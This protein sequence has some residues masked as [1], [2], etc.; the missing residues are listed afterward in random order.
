MPYRMSVIALVLGVALSILPGCST[1]TG[2]S[3]NASSSRTLMTE[4]ASVRKSL[5]QLVDAYENKQSTRFMALVAE[6]Y[7]GDGSILESTIRSAFSA[8]H[9][10][11]IRFSVTHTT[12]SENGKAAIGV[13]FTTTFETRSTGKVA[14]SNGTTELVFKKEGGVYKLYSMQRPFLFGTTD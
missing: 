4:Q 14:K 10:V 3:N 9:N 7:V 5:E 11:R 1:A 12:M 8:N 6:D 13:N 2:S